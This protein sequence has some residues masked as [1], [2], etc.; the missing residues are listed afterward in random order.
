MVLRRRALVGDLIAHAALPGVCLAF[1]LTGERQFALLLAGAALSGLLGV[2]LVSVIT[3]YSRTKED[4]A[5]G[6]V[7]GTFF[8]A[9]IV[10]IAWIARTHTGN[11]AGLESY[12]FGQAASMSR[13]DLWA[14]VAVAVVGLAS[15]AL[16]YKEFKLLSFDAD[17][18]RSQ[19]WPSGLIDLAMMAL[20]TLIVVAGLPAVGVV[21]MAAMLIIPSAAARFWTDRLGSMLVVAG[22]LGIMAAAIGTWFSDSSYRD[23][24][25][26]DPLAFGD[27]TKGLPTGPLI[28]LAG[29]AMLVISLVV[30]PRRGLVARLWSQAALRNRVAQEHLLRSLYEL[31]E[32]R[33]P[34]ATDVPL[35]ALA[36]SHGW[37]GSHTRRHVRRAE[38]QGLV[39]ADL[40]RTRLTPA[41]QALAA[42]LTRRHRLWELYLI[43]GVNIAPDHVDRDADDIEHHLPA[44]LLAQLEAELSP[45]QTQTSADSVPSSPHHLETMPVPLADDP[46]KP[47]EGQP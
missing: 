12:L 3:R 44:A 25:P 46:P 47:A 14:I 29:A 37:S 17:F 32:P 24:L 18:A 28:V 20:V 38:R 35:K 8:G 22:T 27:I 40:G 10:L 6:I 15:V 5:L 39:D 19:G 34:L 30:A 33:L 9:G 16:L 21:L 41:G 1:L 36:E 45:I 2:I 13:Q 26:F 31:A 4:A 42:E 7:L 43:H 11:K 23:V